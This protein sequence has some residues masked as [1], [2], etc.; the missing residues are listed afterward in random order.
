MS[1][2]RKLTDQQAREVKLNLVEGVTMVTLARTYGVSLSTIQ[3]IKQGLTYTH[4]WVEGEQALRPEVERVALPVEKVAA[5]HGKTEAQLD[6]EA[7]ASQ[8]RL[9]KLLSAENVVRDAQREV[10][11]MAEANAKAREML[12]VK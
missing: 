5:F 10:D 12:G 9:L 1:G 4:V 11:G 6:A 3:S 2:K 7:E 8:E